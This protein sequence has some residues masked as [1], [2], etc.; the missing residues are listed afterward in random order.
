MVLVVCSSSL[1]RLTLRPWGAD[2]EDLCPG[3]GQEKLFVGPLFQFLRD[4]V[5]AREF[6]GFGSVEQTGG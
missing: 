3:T 2:E 6:V 4:T 1:T 5:D